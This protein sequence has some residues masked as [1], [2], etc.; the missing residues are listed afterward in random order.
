MK[1]TSIGLWRISCGQS[2]IFHAFLALC[3][4]YMAQDALF[5]IRAC[6]NGGSSD[7]IVEVLD[8]PIHLK[9]IAYCL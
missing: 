2:S 1:P 7:A 9:F 4:E 8:S 3:M 5:G 6:A